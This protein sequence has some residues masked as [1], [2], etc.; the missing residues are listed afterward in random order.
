[1]WFTLL[2]ILLVIV[3]ALYYGEDTSKYKQETEDFITWRF[4]RE[5]GPNEIVELAINIVKSSGVIERL[6]FGYEADDTIRSFKL[7]RTTSGDIRMFCF[8]M[9][10]RPDLATRNRIIYCIRDW[11]SK[12]TPKNEELLQ[13][14]QRLE[15]EI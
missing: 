15:E 4:D 9:R 1:M 6:E 12:I 5:L 7:Q 14:Q 10:D 13:F 11:M 3:I 2:V 8:D